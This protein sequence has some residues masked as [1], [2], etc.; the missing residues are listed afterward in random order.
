MKIV[1][2]CIGKTAFPFVNDGIA[3]YEKRLRKYVDF[4]LKSVP[5]VKNAA[6]LSHEELKR[7]EAPLLLQQVQENDVVLLLDERGQEK[8]SVDFARFL[9]HQRNAAKKRLVCIVGGAYGVGPDIEQR[10]DYTLSLSAMTLPHDLV[11]LL[12]VEQLYRAMT[13]LAGEKYH[14]E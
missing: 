13:I 11:R 3:E 5:T 10:A 2:L 6:S 9:Q 12:F 8:R 4:E 1:L 14:H 7:R